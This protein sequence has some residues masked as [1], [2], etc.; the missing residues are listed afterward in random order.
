MQK[1]RYN[2]ILRQK[3]KWFYQT[4]S[5]AGLSQI[6]ISLLFDDLGLALSNVNFRN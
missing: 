2:W 3:N 4:L 5:L 6:L 1:F